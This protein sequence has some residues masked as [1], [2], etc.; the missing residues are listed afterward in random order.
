MIKSKR[1]RWEGLVS[2]MEAK[3]FVGKASRKEII[4]KIKT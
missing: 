1:L 4:R 2:H 3:Y